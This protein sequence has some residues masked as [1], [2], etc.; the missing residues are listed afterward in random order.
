MKA[1]KAKKLYKEIKGRPTKYDEDIHCQMILQVMADS[2]KG[3]LS[4]FCVEAKISERAFYKWLHAHELFEECYSL[5]KM[6]ARKNW[7][8]EGRAIRDGILPPGSISYRFEHWRMIGWSQFGIGKVSKIR[9][10]LEPNAT[11]NEHYKQLIKQASDGDFTAS[12]IKQL[13]EAI[14]VGLNAHQVFKLQEEINEIKK[15]VEIMRAN[16]NGSNKIS[17]TQNMLL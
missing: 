6:Y 4:S 11:P 7:E 8:E 5:G 13:M 2:E 3:T 17:T 16:S 12:E 14:N 10:G 1:E 15:D 9:L